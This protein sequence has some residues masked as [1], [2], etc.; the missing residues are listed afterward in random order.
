M[1]E[2]RIVGVT[3]TQNGVNTFFATVEPFEPGKM[4]LFRNGVLQPEDCVLEL[5]ASLGTF[6]FLDAEYPII[7]VEILLALITVAGTLDAGGGEVPIL[8]LL[9]CVIP[10]QVVDGELTPGETLR[11]DLTSEVLTGTLQPSPILRGVVVPHRTISG[12]LTCQEDG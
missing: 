11:G 8:P 10:F 12:V 7:A 2:Q 1:A 3:G 9:G 4:R 6:E 5:D